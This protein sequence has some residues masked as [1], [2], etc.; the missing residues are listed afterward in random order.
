MVARAPSARK[1]ETVTGVSSH[2]LICQASAAADDVEHDDDDLMDAPP[3]ASRA[4]RAGA[5]S[6]ARVERA[7][8]LGGRP[9]P[10]GR[11]LAQ[12]ALDDVGQRRSGMSGQRAASGRASL[13]STRA[14]V[15]SVVAAANGCTPQ[16]YSY[17]ST[18]NAK[19]SARASTGS[20]FICSG[21]M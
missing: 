11:R 12:A 4:G 6:P 9:E 14:T 3:G 16:A 10:L 19:T 15:A 2:S 13:S 17:S 21:A 7:D 8:E 1:S 20:P 5:A 18:P